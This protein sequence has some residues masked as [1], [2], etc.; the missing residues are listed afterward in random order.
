MDLDFAEVGRTGIHPF[1]VFDKICWP[2]SS[3][4]IACQP[5]E[6]RLGP[7]EPIYFF[8]CWKREHFPTFSK[9]RVQNTV[10]LGHVCLTCN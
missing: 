3:P 6:A 4:H 8:A 2:P 10:D 7:N 1:L 5:S 9:Q